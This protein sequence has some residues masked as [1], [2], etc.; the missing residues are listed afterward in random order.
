VRFLPVSIIRAI[1]RRRSKNYPSTSEWAGLTRAFFAERIA[2]L[3]K[4]DLIQFFESGMETAREFKL[5]PQNWSGQTLLLSSKDD[6]TTFKRLSEM[7]A[8]YPA[9]QSHVF[10]QGGHHTLLL[11]P[12]IYNSTLTNFLNGLT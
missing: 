3:D 12:E 5:E 7:Q 6:T 2:T 4:A 1:F 10:E 11:F 9:A 8:R